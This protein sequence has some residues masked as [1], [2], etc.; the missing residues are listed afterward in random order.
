[1]KVKR[2]RK[3]PRNLVFCPPGDRENQ[4]WIAELPEIARE[5]Q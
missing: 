4:R 1:L 5:K 2:K 3:P